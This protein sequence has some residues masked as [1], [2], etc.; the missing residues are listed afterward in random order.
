VAEDVSYVTG[1]ALGRGGITLY[2]TLADL[3][4]TEGAVGQ[5]VV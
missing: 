3:V 4:M 1:D 2:D 5:D